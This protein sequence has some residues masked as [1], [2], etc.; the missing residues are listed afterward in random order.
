MRRVARA[1]RCAT[2]MASLRH[3]L[4]WCSLAILLLNDHVLK[5]A[6]VLPGAVTGKL[7]DFAGLIVAPVLAAALLRARGPR[8]RALAFGIPTVPF[9]AINVAPIAASLMESA[10][11][12]AGVP[13]KIWTDPTDLIAL[14][15]LP[16]AWHVMDGAPVTERPRAVERAAIVL[17]AFACMAT[18]PPP[19]APIDA[20][21]FTPT[22]LSNGTSESIDVRIGWLDA[23]VACGD[24]IGNM[25]RALDPDLFGS[26]ITFE[27]TAGENLPL[28]R[29]SAFQAAG[30][31]APAATGPLDCDVA[32]VNADGIR[33]TLVLISGSARNVPQRGD[34]PDP[35]G[36]VAIVPGPSGGLRLE[37]NGVI[38]ALANERPEPSGCFDA[39]VQSFESSIAGLPS[40]GSYRLDDRRE[41]PD[42]CL[43][44]S[45]T[46][47][48][49]ETAHSIFLCV[50][51]W[52]FTFEAGDQ[53]YV[54]VGST[55]SLRITEEH[56]D[57]S[58][59]A[60]VELLSIA[61][62]GVLAGRITGRLEADGC[63]GERLDCDAYVRSV[64]LRVT[65]GATSMSV[66]PGDIVNLGEV[67][68]REVALA[69]GRAEEVIV[70]HPGCE[71]RRRELGA[72]ADIILLYEEVVR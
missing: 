3:P 42:G 70:A 25:E 1:L 14:A 54:S 27:L 50:P 48:L 47:T 49:D 38:L 12:L 62:A 34:A 24:V 67:D 57:G 26:A 19:P 6:G 53:L 71:P 29:A 46:D 33:G 31:G 41:L 52:A 40:L 68:G 56:A 17:G 63:V 8:A 44:L 23:D 43:A 39:S 61:G 11:A 28:D 35:T 55:G 60:A 7:S 30:L 64:T 15:S 69:L 13:W 16:M 51:P 36:Q 65:D 10:T 18:S 59:G 58:L 21:Y 2:A 45:L 9:V 20:S 5:H 37:P 22:Y 72:H 32:L 66:R 4:F